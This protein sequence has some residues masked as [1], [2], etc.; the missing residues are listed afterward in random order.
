MLL[1]ASFLGVFGNYSCLAHREVLPH[2]M[3]SLRFI[4]E[5][6][7]AAEDDAMETLY[8]SWLVFRMATMTFTSFLV[9]SFLGD[10]LSRLI[11]IQSCQY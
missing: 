10:S 6:L 7:S 8:Y 4:G 9:L 2:Y 1:S 3:L 5:L 11:G